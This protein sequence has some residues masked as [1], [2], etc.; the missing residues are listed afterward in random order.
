MKHIGIDLGT[1]NSLVAL[2]KIKTE[3]L[4]NA[5]K[6][7][8]TR[9]CITRRSVEN[10]PKPVEQ[11]GFLKKVFSKQDKSLR[12]EFIVGQP[13]F[14]W[15]KQD[16]ANTIVSI[17]R[18]MG[19]GYSE[20]EIQNII[21][22]GKLNYKIGESKTGTENSL[23]IFLGKDAFLPEEIS[24][25]ILKKLKKDTETFLQES[26]EHAVITV[27]AYFNDKQKY[28]TRI[29]A[30]KAGFT[31]LRLLAEPTAAAISFG[32]DELDR[33]RIS[34][35]TT[36]SEEKDEDED[37]SAK[38]ILVYDFGG[39]TFDVSILTY[40][41]GQFI[42]QGKSGDMW[43]GGD[44]IDHFLID[45]VLQS[46]AEEHEINDIAK[47]IDQM[48]KQDQNILRG[49]LLEKVEK[50]K[51][52]LSSRETALVEVLGLLK[53][54]GDLIDIE[55][56]LSRKEFE[57]ILEPTVRKSIQICK[58]LLEEINLTP[59]MID[60]YLLIGG[61]T[62]IPLVRKMMKDEF[63]EDK[64]LIHN[65]PMYAVAQGAA[66][67]AHKLSNQIECP[68]CGH[69]CAA[70]SSSCEKCDYDFQE[71]EIRS[72]IEDIVYSSSHDYY[73]RLADS[74]MHKI[75]ERN[76]PLPLE[77]EDIFK[78][79]AENQQIIHLQFINLVNEREESIGD[80]WMTLDEGYPA[81]TEIAVTIRIDS[82]NVFEISA[83]LVKNP[84][85][86]ISRILS[87]GSADEKLFMEIERI[88]EQS[89]KEKLY[90]LKQKELTKNSVEIISQA[91][92]LID[93]KTGKIDQELYQRL[94]SKL[95]LMKFQQK[96]EISPA[97]MINYTHNALQ[98]FGSMI[99]PGLKA[100][101]EK[102]L[103]RIEILQGKNQIREVYRE[104][105]RLAFSLD[106]L[107]SLVQ[108]MIRIGQMLYVFK[109]SKMYKE[110]DD[111]EKKFQE[112]FEYYK[113]NDFTKVYSLISKI[114][115]KYEEKYYICA[116][117]I[118]FAEITK[119]IKK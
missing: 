88:I 19:R 84:E 32:I 98:S 28:A 64:V 23:C 15:M 118:E 22:Q 75:I 79:V 50:A 116:G 72:K 31:V 39:G 30:Q 77:T 103:Q 4:P 59:D 95:E 107:D 16:P 57:E 104:C 40:I 26:I 93:R 42:E 96:E 37:D 10:E 66:I 82:D 106:K 20:P 108:S 45:K 73:L 62:Y 47:T 65:E 58:N 33:S 36:P 110:A 12:K 9:S 53:D 89:K 52:E 70:D 49:T 35:K 29:A 44:D 86:K 102:H 113:K 68:V 17:K 100:K 74:S 51:I 13:A 67:L 105:E 54:K 71:Q 80:L 34:N 85:I 90:I 24:A 41:G 114:F 3:I 11:T 81:G 6:S 1:T 83:H 27:P 21:K 91:D 69:I 43:L 99:E 48:S 112:I 94:H 7:N 87:R 46:T 109:D 117:K 92:L 63:G 61:T 18:L 56:E 119:G 8:L 55:V 97:G 76:M 25:E 78:T 60:N 14:E 115:F 101:L 5:E 38:T 2:K 111:I